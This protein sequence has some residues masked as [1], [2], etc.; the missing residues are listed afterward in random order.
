MILSGH[1][2]NYLPYPGLIGKIL[3]SD[4]FIYVSNVQLE[5]KSW[6]N[7]NRIKGANGEIM[8]TVPVMTKGKF[9]Q[10]ISETK[11]NNTEN[12]RM[13]HFNA[14]SLNYKKAPY[15]SNYM[16]FFEDLYKRDWEYLNDLDIHIMNYVLSELGIKT[17][18]YYDTDFDFQ[19]SN[20]ALLVEMTKTLSCD[21]YLSNKGS[22]SYVDISAFT[23]NGLNHKYLDYKGV[24]YPQCFRGFVPYLSIFDMMFNIGSERTLEIIAN[25]ENYRYSALNEKI[26]EE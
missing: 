16:D 19:G 4:K 18:I 14:I 17:E 21:T 1:Q 23:S 8:L 25:P 9:E 20:N 26:T 13:K 24:E 11:I 22:D 5:K 12:W 3:Q 6:Q 2:P 10:K 15:A 7:R